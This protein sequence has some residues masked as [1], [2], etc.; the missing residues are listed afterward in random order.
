MP[1]GVNGVGGGGGGG[2]SLGGNGGGA[3]S[4]NGGGNGGG[5]GDGLVGTPLPLS[6]VGG[7]NGGKGVDGGGEGVVACA[8]ST[9][10]YTPSVIAASSSGTPKQ[11]AIKD[12]M[13][14]TCDASA[15]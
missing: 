11:S 13:L 15:T 2:L 10:V 4:S 3:G 9:V 8:C 14:Y 6:P 1:G 5:S 12:C 7:G